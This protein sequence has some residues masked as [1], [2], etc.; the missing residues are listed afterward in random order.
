[1]APK[2][3]KEERGTRPQCP[4]TRCENVLALLAAGQIS[5]IS[6]PQKCIKTKLDIEN[7]WAMLYNTL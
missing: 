1:V 6:R 2:A 4:E 7:R 3:T 5:P